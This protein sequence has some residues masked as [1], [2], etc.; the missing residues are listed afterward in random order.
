MRMIRK[1]LSQMLLICFGLLV[2]SGVYALINLDTERALPWH[3][4]LGCLLVGVLG[5]LTQLAF[6]SRR[7]LTA[8][9]LRARTAVHFLCLVGILTAAGWLSGWFA[10]FPE[11]LLSVLV[12]CI[13]YGAAWLGQTITLWVEARRINKALDRMHT[14]EQEDRQHLHQ[15]EDRQHLRQQGDR[16]S[17][18]RAEDKLP[19]SKPDGGNPEYQANEGDSSYLSEDGHPAYR[20]DNTHTL[21]LSE[22]ENLL[23]QADEESDDPLADKDM[24]KADRTSSVDSV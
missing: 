5:A 6:H 15:Q 2:W 23:D 13:V 7:A 24:S 12:F 20:L 16:Q 18:R 19:L 3:F 9:E 4:P 1:M 22:D 21:F 8:G 14:M 17:L 10:S 11:Y